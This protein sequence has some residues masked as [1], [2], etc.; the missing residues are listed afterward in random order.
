MTSERFQRISKQ[1]TWRNGSEMEYK[2]HIFLAN[3]DPV[4]GS[5]QGKTRPVLV[6]SQEAINQI[7]PVV[8]TLP[9]TTRKPGRKIYPNEVLIPVGVGGL[10]KESIVLCYQIRT[11]D[12]RRLMKEIGKIDNL[13]LQKAIINA[14]CFQL[15][16]VR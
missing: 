12:K 11:L 3:L 7:L 16:I 1:L 6:I 5:E 10:E 8:N 9:I 2:W 14:F 15:E 13:E 4:I